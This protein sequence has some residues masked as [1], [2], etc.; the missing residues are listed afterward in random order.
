VAASYLKQLTPDVL[1]SAVTEGGVFLKDTVFLKLDEIYQRFVV[2]VN[3]SV[4]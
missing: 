1:R 3:P 4:T 2:N